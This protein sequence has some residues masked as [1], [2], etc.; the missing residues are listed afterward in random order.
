MYVMAGQVQTDQELEDQRP[1]RERGGEE[2]EEASCGAA[3]C[4]HVENS[5]ELG[6]LVEGAGCDAIESVEEAGKAVKERAGAWVEGHVVEG[7]YGEDD[8]RV[9]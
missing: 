8:A 5:A 6:R 3:I 9:A 2:D 1:S 7:C 4:D